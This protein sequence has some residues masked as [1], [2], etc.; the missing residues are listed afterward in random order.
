M[1][2]ES[3]EFEVIH[4][5]GKRAQLGESPFFDPA[6]RR[7]WWVD[8]TGKRIHMADTCSGE[9]RAWDTPEFPGFVVLNASSRPVVGMQTGIFAFDPDHCAFERLVTL[10]QPDCRF[11]DATV[12]PNG[13]LWVSTI[14]NHSKAESGAVHRIRDSLELETVASGLTIPNGLAVDLSRGRLFYSD[15][16]PS[17]QTIWTRNM[18]SGKTGFS[19][20]QIFADTRAMAGRPDGAALD[21]DG[22]YWIAGVDGAE[23][24]VFDPRGDLNT[25]VSV[26]FTA[27]TKLSFSGPNG[28]TLAV[29]SKIGNGEGGVVALASMPAKMA[30]GIAQPLWKH[31]D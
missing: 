16:H 9:V 3:L 7:L 14:D 23:I 1:K 24:Y 20:P 26:P 8:I 6:S 15:S 21:E 28:R 2:H 18:V 11:N 29:T 27:P 22:F 31:G 13:R 19:R 4:P 5:H 12:D 25:S 30:A 17:I 10:N